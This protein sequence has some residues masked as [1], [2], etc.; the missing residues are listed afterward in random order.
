MNPKFARFTHRRAIAAEDAAG[1]IAFDDVED[2]SLSI[3]DCVVSRQSQGLGCFK[4]AAACA[5]CWCRNTTVNLLAP[6]ILT[7]LW[8]RIG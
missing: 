5:H 1:A 7:A 3:D 6:L 8:A 4:T 2:L